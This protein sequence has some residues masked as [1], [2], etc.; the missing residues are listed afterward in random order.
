MYNFLIKV[1]YF[2]KDN[3]NGY[4]NILFYE[5]RDF[6]NWFIKNRQKTEIIDISDKTW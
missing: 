3:I 2:E 5:H 6:Y 1:K 4:Q